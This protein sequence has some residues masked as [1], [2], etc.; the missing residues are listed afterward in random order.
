MRGIGLA[1]SA[2]PGLTPTELGSV[3]RFVRILL[4]W[5]ERLRTMTERAIEPEGADDDDAIRHLDGG[6]NV[7]AGVEQRPGT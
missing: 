6:R 3:V 2:A 5:D 7:R 1:T 4:D